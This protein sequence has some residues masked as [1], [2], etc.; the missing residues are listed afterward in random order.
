MSQLDINF[1]VK[2]IFET[3]KEIIKFNFPVE[4]QRIAKA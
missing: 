1:D 2:K 3:N 4:K